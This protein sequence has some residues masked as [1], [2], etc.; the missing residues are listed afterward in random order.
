MANT[1]RPGIDPATSTYYVPIA[2]Q[3]GLLLLGD[4]AA[5]YFTA[6]WKIHNCEF[7]ALDTGCRVVGQFSDMSNDSNIHCGSCE[8]GYELQ[9]VQHNLVN[10]RIEGGGG[11]FADG[12]GSR[13]IWI[14]TPE[15]GGQVGGNVHLLSNINIELHKPDS[16][17]ILL[18]AGI[19]NNKIVNYYNS[20]ADFM[21]RQTII[22]NSKIVGLH[23]INDYTL[24]SMVSQTRR[25]SGTVYF[26]LGKNANAGWAEEGILAGNVSRQVDGANTTFATLAFANGPMMNL[27]TGASAGSVACIFYNNSEGNRWYVNQYPTMYVRFIPS[28]TTGVRVYMGFWSQFTAPTAST[29]VLANKRGVGLWLDTAVSANWKIMHNDNSASSQ[30]ANFPS[31]TYGLTAYGPNAISSGFVQSVTVQQTIANPSASVRHHGLAFDYKTTNIPTTS[32][33]QGF[34]I[35]VE[36]TTA[37]AK[38]L[39]LFD[40][41]LQLTTI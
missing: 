12:V 3:T 6:N 24:P 29:D 17:G 9:G 33:A 5:S 32:A 36:R 2:A 20:S 13:G 11:G 30:I 10:F 25:R 23:S 38:T 14:R 18:D 21:T 40:M 31:A 37:G 27:T 35:M 1:I 34:L 8:T 22:D 7:F 26:G 16:V 41:E 28:S 19:D 15:F 39:R 4:H